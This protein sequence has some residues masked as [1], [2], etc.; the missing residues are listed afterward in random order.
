MI[1]F[2]KVITTYSGKD[3]C[4]CGCRGT[5][6]PVGPAVK[7]RVNKLNANWERVERFPYPGGETCYELLDGE[8]VTWVYVQE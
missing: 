2:A 7:R 6:A 3:G 5:Y 8:R 1:D 4:A